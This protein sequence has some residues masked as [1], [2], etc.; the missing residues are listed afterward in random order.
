MMPIHRFMG[1]LIFCMGI[2]SIIS[3]ITEKA[4]FTYAGEYQHLPGWSVEANLL[5]LAVALYAVGIGILVTNPSFSREDNIAQMWE[6]LN[7]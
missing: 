7:D 6:N 2:A 5:G 4:I 3:G 1:T